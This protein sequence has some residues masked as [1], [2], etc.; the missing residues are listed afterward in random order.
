MIT[1]LGLPNFDYKT[2]K[3]QH[4]TPLCLAHSL[5]NILA[6]LGILDSHI[7]SHWKVQCQPNVRFVSMGSSHNLKRHLSLSHNLIFLI[8]KFRNLHSMCLFYIFLP[9]YPKMLLNQRVH[10]NKEL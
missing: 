1:K 2:I 9:N 6:F 8:F 4:P 3:G 10:K 7:T 5:K